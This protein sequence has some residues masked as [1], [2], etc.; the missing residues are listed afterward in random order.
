MCYGCIFAQWKKEGEEEEE[1]TRCS[2]K[3]MSE[4]S[5]GGDASFAGDV[6]L[7]MQKSSG[8]RAHI[9]FN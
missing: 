1:P 8:G 7:R 3:T 4:V 6:V 9:R 5:T 2:E